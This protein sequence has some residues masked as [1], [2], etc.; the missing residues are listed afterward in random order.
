MSRSFFVF[1]FLRRK[2]L[3]LA[4]SKN[5]SEDLSQYSVSMNRMLETWI[6]K[7]LLVRAQMEMRNILLETSG[8]VIS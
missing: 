1:L 7:V 3:L 8:K 5:N 6:I 4:V 2:D